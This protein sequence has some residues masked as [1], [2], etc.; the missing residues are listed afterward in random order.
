MHGATITAWLVCAMMLTGGRSVMAV[1]EAAYEVVTKDGVFELRDYAPQIVAEV[2]IEGSLEEAGNEAFRP[3]FRYI[4]GD[5]HARTKIP[6]TAP[7]SQESAGT[8]IAMTAPVSQVKTGDQWAVSFMMPASSTM[9]AIPVPDNPAVIIR[10]NPARRMAAV[11]YSG[12][13][14]EKSYRRHLQELEVWMQAR[15]LMPAGD[16]VW[17]RY[18]AP[19]VPWFM[20]RNEILVPVKVDPSP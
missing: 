1:E 16:P 15:A 2:V 6:M 17:A 3:L 20:R 14:S 12:F 7:V 10:E 5:N 4:D 19:F 11:R 13:W 8:K 18:N 9:E